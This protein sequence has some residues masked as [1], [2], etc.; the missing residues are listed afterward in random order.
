MGKYYAIE[1]N[2]RSARLIIY[3]YISPWRLMESDV[4]AWS[5][6][7]ELQNLDADEIHV[8]INTDGGSVAEGFAIYNALRAHPAKIITHADGFVA[9]AGIFPFLAG[10]ERIANIVSAFYFHPV[11]ISAKGGPKELRKAADQAEL[12]SEQGLHAFAAVGVSAEAARALEERDDFATPQEML[13]LGIATAIAG[14]PESAEATQSILP[15]FVERVRREE[16]DQKPEGEMQTAMTELRA[17]MA[18][19]RAEIR[20][21]IDERSVKLIEGEPD[22]DKGEPVGLL[23]DLDE[24]TGDAPENDAG[25]GEP[26]ES[27]QNTEPEGD[28]QARKK[29]TW[30]AFWGL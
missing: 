26:G 25:D 20:D 4:S 21:L 11:Q 27:A 5:I 22:P 3:G 8:H 14:L 29:N 28:G 15:L 12:L 13:E 19:L 17:A 16:S 1:Q 7:K 2:G 9:S 10:E 18:E 30:R 23:E 24:E 6:Q